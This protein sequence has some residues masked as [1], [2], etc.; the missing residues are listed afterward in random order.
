MFC[1]ATTVADVFSHSQ[2]FHYK[3]T[4]LKSMCRKKVGHFNPLPVELRVMSK[5]D[6]TTMELSGMK[7]TNSNIVFCRV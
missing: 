3:N 6:K 4:T 5:I 1:E 7:N 2:F